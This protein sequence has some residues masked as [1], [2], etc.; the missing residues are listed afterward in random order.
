L[1]AVKGTKTANQ[2]AQEF[3]AHLTE[4]KSMKNG[5]A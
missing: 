1:E 5:L 3:G 4:V 2:I